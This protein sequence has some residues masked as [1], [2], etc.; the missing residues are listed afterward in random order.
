MRV[1]SRTLTTSRIIGDSPPPGRAARSR[2][3]GGRGDAE[4]DH[5]NDVTLTAEDRELARRGRT[6]RGEHAADADTDRRQIVRVGVVTRDRLAPDL[7]G[8]VE[9]GRSQRH[10]V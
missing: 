10:L 8:A 9:A 3:R 2:G 1:L 6:V 7:A 5:P 4:L